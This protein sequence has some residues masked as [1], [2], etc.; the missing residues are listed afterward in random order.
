MP[1]TPL[2]QT[3]K[4]SATHSIQN[5]LDSDRHRLTLTDLSPAVLSRLMRQAWTDFY[6]RPRP[7]ARILRD[8]I[9]SG[10]LDEVARLSK[11]WARWAR[12]A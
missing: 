2:F 9:N 1:G 7:M 10:S 8:A 6:L 11:A 4:A 5:P 3:H 12:T